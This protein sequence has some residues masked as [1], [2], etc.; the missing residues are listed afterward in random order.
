MFVTCWGEN[1]VDLS[2]LQQAGPTQNAAGDLVSSFPHPDPDPGVGGLQKNS[3]SK[4]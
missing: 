3:R 1:S 4:A 2:V